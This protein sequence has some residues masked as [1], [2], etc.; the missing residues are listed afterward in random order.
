MPIAK[1]NNFIYN[2][3]ILI[4]AKGVKKM[5]NN[6]KKKVFEERLQQI[7][8]DNN[9]TIYT[10]AEIVDLSPA[11]I[12]R[13]LNTSMTPKKTTV[14]I[15]AQHFRLN[16][17]WLMGYD[18]PKK[19]DDTIINVNKKEKEL[20]DKYKKLNDEQ[21][22]KLEGIIEGMLM[23]NTDIEDEHAKKGA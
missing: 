4:F 20:L 2:N 16:P 12:S 7:M 18:V 1:S 9:E 5:T 6:I 17:A 10:I 23:S 13:Y 22:I 11:T 3:S 8:D 21:K 19:L 15:L 14:K